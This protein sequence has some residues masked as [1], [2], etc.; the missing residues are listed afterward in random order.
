MKIEKPFCIIATRDFQSL[1][2]ILND[3]EQ[4]FYAVTVQNF[5]IKA[6]VEKDL[7]QFFCLVST[8][9]DQRN[10]YLFVSN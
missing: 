8:G 1:T 9:E 3:M 10:R 6:C 2:Y 4:C 7:E 5:Q